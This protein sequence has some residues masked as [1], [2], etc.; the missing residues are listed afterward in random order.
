MTSIPARRDVCDGSTNACQHPAARRALCARRPRVRRG[1]DLRRANPECPP[2]RR[3]RRSARAAAGVCDVPRPATGAW[4]TARP[5]SWC[6]GH[7]VAA[8]RRAC[9]DLTETC[10]GRASTVPRTGRA[11][12]CRAAAGVCDVAESCDGVSNDCPADTFQPRPSSAA[13]R[14]APATPAETCHR[15]GRRLSRGRESTAVCR[16]AAGP[17]D[18]AERCDGT[19]TTARPTPSSPRPSNAARRRASATCRDLRRDERACRPNQ[20]HGG[21]AA[22]GGGVRRSRELR[23]GARRLPR[24]RAQPAG[25]VCRPAA[26][27]ATWPRP[28]TAPPWPAR[29]TPSS[30]RP[31]SAGP[32]RASAI[33]PS[34]AA[35]RARAAPPTCAPQ[36][37]TA[38]A[39]CDLVD[40]CPWTRPAQPTAT[41]RHRRCRRPGTN[42]VPV[43]A[44]AS[45]HHDQ[46]SRRGARDPYLQERD[47]GAHHPAI[48]PASKAR[49]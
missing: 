3:A 29:R 7:G 27:C 16:P 34:S 44:V 12:V 46:T 10:T 2:M 42:I 6:R 43:F 41:A 28:A 4:T 26:A 18:V 22:G 38:T 40:D 8:R 48:D 11:R 47:H 19:S 45:P 21:C 49:V 39:V 33:P 1:R 32:R 17:C 15:H 14:P 13:R 36:T 30:P 35:A 5:M 25:T 20:E 9:A 23:R 24:R 31:P 37:P